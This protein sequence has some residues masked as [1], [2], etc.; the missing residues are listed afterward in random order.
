MNDGGYPQ[1]PLDLRKPCESVAGQMDHL[2]PGIDP[3]STARGDTGAVWL[4]QDT[5]RSS[6]PLTVPIGTLKKSQSAS[7]RCAPITPTGVRDAL[8]TR[9]WI[10][11]R[12]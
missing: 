4:A 10:G 1:V 12:E 9:K 7:A 6:S 8:Q 11:Q 5:A 3:G 2:V